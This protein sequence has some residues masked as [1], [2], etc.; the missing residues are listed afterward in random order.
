MQVPPPVICPGK[1]AAAIVLVY[2]LYL[3]RQEISR[4][5]RGVF[6]GARKETSFSLRFSLR[7]LVETKLIL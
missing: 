7:P 4:E 1:A 3:Y 5:E 2:N 6:R